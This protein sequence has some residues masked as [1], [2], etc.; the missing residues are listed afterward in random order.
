MCSFTTTQTFIS[1]STLHLHYLTPIHSTSTFDDVGYTLT[2]ALRISISTIYKC[3]KTHKQRKLQILRAGINILNPGPTCA[4]C[5]LQGKKNQLVKQCHLCQQWYHRTCLQIPSYIFNT[6]I[7]QNSDWSCN[8]CQN[9]THDKSICNICKKYCKRW[10][11]QKC[12]SCDD[13]FHRSCIEKDIGKK[14][15][16]T[17]TKCL[18]CLIPPSLSNSTSIIPSVQLRKGVRLAHIK[19][20]DIFSLNKFDEIK[21]LLHQYQFDVP[22]IGET[23]LYDKINDDELKIAGFHLIRRDRTLATKPNGGGGASCLHSRRLGFRNDFIP[24][25]RPCRNHILQNQ[26]DP[27]CSSS[28]L[29][30]LSTRIW[31]STI[32]KNDFRIHG[33]LPTEYLHFRRY[34]YRYFLFFLKC[35]NPKITTPPTQLHPGDSICYTNH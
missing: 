4:I 27:H 9:A 30:N 15:A 10:I 31:I 1:L 19:V 3:P 29:R 16:K 28:Y 7:L 34:E 25:P 6:K 35:Q 26:E 20:R 22:I 2:I 21:I 14:S 17:N 24:L 5:S 18:N 13:N 23:W 11:I 8:P 32:S 12:E 33:F